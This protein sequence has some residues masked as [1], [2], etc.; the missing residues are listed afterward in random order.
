M[1]DE[2][3]ERLGLIEENSWENEEQEKKMTFKRIQQIKGR[4]WDRVSEK[5]NMGDNQ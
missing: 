5:Q 4:A 2:T 3:M 1:E